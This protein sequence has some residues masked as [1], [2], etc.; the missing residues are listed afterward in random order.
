MTNKRTTKKSAAAKTTAKKAAASKSS[1]A[2]EQAA[3]ERPIVTF[4]EDGTVV[5]ENMP[6]TPRGRQSNYDKVRQFVIEELTEHV[7]DVQKR[8]NGLTK[9]FEAAQ[10]GFERA[11]RRHAEELEERRRSSVSLHK[12]I[13]QATNISVD[14]S[15][16]IKVTQMLGESFDV[17]LIRAE[18]GFNPSATWQIGELQ[19]DFVGGRHR[20]FKAISTERAEEQIVPQDIPLG[21]GELTATSISFIRDLLRAITH[22]GKKKLSSQSAYASWFP[23]TTPSTSPSPATETPEQPPRLDTQATDSL[24]RGRLKAFP[25]CPQTTKNRIDAVLDVMAASQD[26]FIEIL[27]TLY[28]FA[29]LTPINGI[30]PDEDKVNAVQHTL[31]TATEQQLMSILPAAILGML[32]HIHN[33]IKATPHT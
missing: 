33:S 7:T 26:S 27:R 28:A 4:H 31:E 16:I 9:D 21:F 3:D 5:I 2:T 1:A 19:I 10:Q 11:Q 14:I 24:S 23:S 22:K 32:G 17:K 6:P 12:Q 15:F 30:Q 13:A 29:E 25:T 8:L 18:T 20:S